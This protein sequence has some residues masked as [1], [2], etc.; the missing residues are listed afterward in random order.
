MIV[1]ILPESL[2]GLRNLLSKIMIGDDKILTAARRNPSSFSIE[3]GAKEIVEVVTGYE[4]KINT[5]RK[6]IQLPGQ[7]AA[8]EYF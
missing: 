4:K 6:L 8:L 1:F 3:Y 2:T 5:C 7:F